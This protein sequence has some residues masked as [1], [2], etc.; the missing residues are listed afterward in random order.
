MSSTVPQIGFDRF[1][2]LDWVT[3]ALEVRAGRSSVDELSA[4]L[5]AAGLSLAARKKTRTVLNRLWLEP[6]PE[7]AA[8]AARGLEIH[9]SASDVSVAALSWGMA[10]A[11]YPFFGKVAELVGRLSALQGD[12]AAAEV[13]RRMS[14]TY[15]ER[16]GTYRMTNM[17]LQSQ[18]SW[19]A[20]ERAE[21]GKRLIRRTPTTVQDDR[22]VAWLIE[23]ALRY[24]GK[25]VSVASLPA[26]A[27]IFP[28][29][30]DRP[31]GY[32]ASN[33]PMLELRSEGAGHQSV[34][35]ASA[36]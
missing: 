35:L 4:M 32:V 10:I 1:I 3:A 13:H 36:V 12:C 24:S 34:A 15:G 20:I 28:F 22:A 9:E 21:K 19:G 11:S 6:R 16:E 23:A 26:M 29:V 14:E 5:E 30:L 31:L 33:S 7:L 27:V 25:A 17:V 2:H 18:A 8:L